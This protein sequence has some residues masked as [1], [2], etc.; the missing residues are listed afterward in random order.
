MEIEYLTPPVP[1]LY[2]TQVSAGRDQTCALGNDGKAYCWGGNVKG[3]LGDNK[4]SG[5]S[6]SYPA[7]VVMPTDPGFGRFISISSGHYH[8]CALGDNL[9]LYCWGS[10]TKGEIGDGTTTDVWVPKLI[11]LP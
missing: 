9:S 1:G 10:N 11:A 3:Q 2:F 4:N 7:A 5:G 6:V 8:V